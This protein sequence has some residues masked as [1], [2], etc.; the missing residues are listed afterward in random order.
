ML[1][2]LP[3]SLFVWRVAALGDLLSFSKKKVGALH[4]SDISK[5]YERNHLKI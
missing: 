5:K 1:V 4:L 3:L 2:L